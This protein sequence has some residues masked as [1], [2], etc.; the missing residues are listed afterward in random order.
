MNSR[1]KIFIPSDSNLNLYSNKKEVGSV[2]EMR[3]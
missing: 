3:M 2:S 1:I